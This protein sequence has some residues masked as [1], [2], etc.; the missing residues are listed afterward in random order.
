MQVPVPLQLLISRM[1]LPLHFGF[2]RAV[3]MAS[4]LA[5]TALPA[6]AQIPNTLLHSIP[7][8]PTGVESRALLGNSVAVDGAYAVVGASADDTGAEDSG[9]AKV[10]DSA[11][12][13]LLFL[14]PN[15][16]PEEHDDFGRSVAIAGTRVVVGAPHD[17][18]DGITAGR[19]YVYDLASD[20]PSVPVAVLSHPQPV[21]LGPTTSYFGWSVAVSGTRVAVGAWGTPV[22]APGGTTTYGAGSAFVYDMVSVTP[23]VPMAVLRMPTPTYQAHFGRS[24]A[25]SGARVVVGAPEAGSAYVYDVASPTAA[26]PVATLHNP[27]LPANDD[28]GFSVA[29]WDT[30]V[31]VGARFD[32]TGATDGGSAYVYDLSSLT[33]D[34]PVVTVNNPD[35]AMQDYFGRSIAI[36]GARL[37]VGAFGDNAGATFA[38]S[39]YVYDLSSGTPAV[40]VVKLPNR[41]PAAGDAFGWS[42][43]ISGTRVVVGAPF[44]DTGATDAGSAYVYE[45]T[46]DLPT[47]PVLTLI[48]PNSA[49]HEN[50]GRS[51]AISG[52]RVVV[53]APGDD[54][55]GQDAGRVFVYDVASA[56]P[57]VPVATLKSP[58]PAAFDYFG[59][60]VAISGS[61]VVVGAYLDDTGSQDAGAVYLFDLN[62]GMPAVPVTILPNPG[63]ERTTFFGG[64]VAIS[65]TRVVVGSQADP[66][67]SPSLG[68]AYVYDLASPSPAVPVAALHNPSAEPAF[69][70]GWTVAIL[71]T[72][73]VV[74]SPYDS[75][76]ALNSGMVYIYD[77]TSGTPAVPVTILNNPSSAEYDRFGNSVSISGSLVVVGAFGDDTGAPDAGIAYVYD[78]A[79]GTPT[80]PVTILTNPDPAEEDYFGNSVAISGTRV[81]VMKWDFNKGVGNA[82]RGYVYDLS[83][84]TPAVPAA[85]LDD[86][87]P[88][89]GDGFET[90]VAIDGATVAIG[91]AFDDTAATD[92]GFAFI[93]G[94]H[95]LDQDSDGLPD[96][97]EIAQFGAT[98]G[99]GALDDFDH[100][101]SNELLEL[102]FG[103]DP[104]RADPGGMPPVI[105]EGDYLTM[106]I[107]KQLGVTYEVQSAGTLQPALPDSFS[108]ASTTV[109]L[110]DATTLKVRDDTKIGIEPDRFMRVKVWAAP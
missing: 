38:G 24:V 66:T 46:G 31:A 75:K 17:K 87:G 71:G 105:N 90:S 32:D 95:P 103:S 35:P 36:F 94:P 92:K 52:T 5:L 104:T 19:A 82:T 102:A 77:L 88:L 99:H 56:T 106:T 29:I 89:A 25:I 18:A 16:T 84:P 60:A 40:P 78:L 33:P 110:D 83:S 42:V 1:P 51:V 53:G 91:A 72:R 8:Q 63:P 98:S 55:H 22:T 34:V 109:L 21:H 67:A 30:R 65:G 107:T 41:E 23:T 76:G 80:V 85:T 81:A 64:A 93:F 4:L 100:D 57:S 74:G 70:F 13:A 39:T 49:V 62:S 96:A 50:F 61:R 54:M 48:H 9:V 2:C 14:L 47:Y 97:W 108:A 37:V 7:P 6:A 10:F 101:G 69:S 59:I 68:S 26:V 20:T 15:P 27:D 12:G 3:P 28:F 44:N 43:A 45:L 11:T 79:S 73:V 86:P 58:D